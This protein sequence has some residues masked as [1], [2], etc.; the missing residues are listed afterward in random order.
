MGEVGGGKG[1]G[2]RGERMKLGS[3]HARFVVA[4]FHSIPLKKPPFRLRGGGGVESM[5]PPRERR[6]RETSFGKTSLR[7]RHYVERRYTTRFDQR[8]GVTAISKK[9]NSET[10][11]R[12]RGPSAFAALPFLLFSDPPSIP[13]RGRALR[14]LHASSGFALLAFWPSIIRSTPSPSFWFSGFCLSA[15]TNGRGLKEYMIEEGEKKLSPRRLA[16]C[17]NHNERPHFMVFP[18]PLQ[19]QEFLLRHTPKKRIMNGAIRAHPF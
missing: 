16:Q 14:L 12:E 17:V 9:I 13:L 1:G 2:E 6:G 11:T 19:Q 4:L 15:T 7:R 5:S 10:L 18:S 3:S 8:D